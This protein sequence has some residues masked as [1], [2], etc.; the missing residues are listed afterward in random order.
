MDTCDYCCSCIYMK[1]EK[2]YTGKFWCTR[3]LEWVY[4]NDRKCY[5]CS[6]E[7][8]DRNSQEDLYRHSIE[9]QYIITAIIKKLFPGLEVPEIYVS[10]VFRKNLEKNSNMTEMLAK[11]DKVGKRIAVMVQY[12]EELARK[13]Y[14]N[15]VVPVMTLIYQG[16]DD[17][18][19]SM[20]IEMVKTMLTKEPL[21]NSINTTNPYLVTTVSSIDSISKS[22]VK[23][24][25]PT[26]R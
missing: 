9:R 23:T 12:D 13:I 2:D 4:A 19:L 15:T 3:K 16:K 7:T 22:Y 26:K 21:Q 24:F 18:A 8:R 11:Y 1:T 5:R 6:Y 25:K 10:S 17:E 14:T 20:Y